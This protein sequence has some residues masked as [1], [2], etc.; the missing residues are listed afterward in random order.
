MLL[1]AVSVGVALGMGVDALLADGD[2][3]PAT[4][5]GA[6]IGP[7][8]SAR[9][10]QVGPPTDVLDQSDRV[11][12]DGLGPVR[13]GMSL[14]QASAAADQALRAVEQKGCT[15]GVPASGSP[16]VR[17]LLQRGRIARVDV[18]ADSAVLTLSGVGV[19][20][21]ADEVRAVYGR[22]LVTAEGGLRFDPSDVRYAVAFDTDDGEVVAVRAGLADVVRNDPCQG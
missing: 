7:V 20:A 16:D 17:F 12:V 6:F 4:A 2:D 1:A 22:R 14:P 19:G 10:P 11:R 3:E 9:P 13:V 15:F 5:Q 18:G 21:D 8:A